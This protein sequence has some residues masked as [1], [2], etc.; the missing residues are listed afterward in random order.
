MGHTLIS[1]MNVVQVYSRFRSVS[2]NLPLA[3]LLPHLN[4]SPFA[5][6]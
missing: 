2:L 4:L 6:E 1:G 5:H 3:G